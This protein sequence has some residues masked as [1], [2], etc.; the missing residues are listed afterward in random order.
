MSKINEGT[1]KTIK[2]AQQTKNKIELSFPTIHRTIILQ[3]K[4]LF[5]IHD[6]HLT[7]SIYHFKK[8]IGHIIL[9]ITSYAANNFFNNYKWIWEIN[10]KI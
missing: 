4:G 7:G 2:Y 10:L 8:S 1:R 5:N 3:K 6:K 9:P